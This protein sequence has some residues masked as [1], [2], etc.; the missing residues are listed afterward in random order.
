MQKD[1]EPDFVNRD[2]PFFSACVGVVLS[3]ESANLSWQVC[4]IASKQTPNELYT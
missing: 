3:E 1:L 2:T 4:K